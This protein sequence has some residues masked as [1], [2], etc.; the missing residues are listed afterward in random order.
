MKQTTWFTKGL[1]PPPR[2]NIFQAALIQRN[3]RP[4]LRRDCDL[5]PPALRLWITWKE[6]KQTTWFTKGLRRLSLSNCFRT[7]FAGN[8]RPDLRRDCDFYNHPF[9]LI[10]QLLKQTTWFTKGLRHFSQVEMTWVCGQRNKRPDLR[11][12]CDFNSWSNLSRASFWKQTT[13]FT[14]GLRRCDGDLIIIYLLCR[15]TNDLIY[16]GIAT[17][18]SSGRSSS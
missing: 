18:R 5:W 17:R 7:S 1:R 12:D 2:H 14:K 9:C 6:G 4:D 15:E 13:W 3:K 10:L 16:E 8:K 11:R